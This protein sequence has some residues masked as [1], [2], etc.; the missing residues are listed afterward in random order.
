LNP[1][2]GT[3]DHPFKIPPNRKGETENEVS[4][5]KAL[6]S[7]KHRSSVRTNIRATPATGG[8]NLDNTNQGH[9]AQ[10]P[11]L[12]TGGTATARCSCPLRG[13]QRLKCSPSQQPLQRQLRV[14]EEVRGGTCSCWARAQADVRLDSILQYTDTGRTLNHLVHR[15][16]G[17]VADKVRSPA[18]LSIPPTV[19]FSPR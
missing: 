6:I 8:S 11:L 4:T 13:T 12:S 3:Q 16:I 14:R 2:S 9:T 17:W 10:R 5:A 15:M 7:F 1:L 19:N 18:R